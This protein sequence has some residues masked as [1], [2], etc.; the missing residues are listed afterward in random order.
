MLKKETGK[1]K[2]RISRFLYAAGGITAVALGVLGIFIPILPTTPFLL[3]AAYLFARSSQKLYRWLLTH[4]LLSI[5]IKNYIYYKAISPK[6]KI[7]SLSLLWASILYSCYITW[8][9]VWLP[10]LLIA[11]AI[12]VTIHILKLRNAP[13]NGNI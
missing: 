10:P 11:I 6:V 8:S 2:T 13:P 5:Y 4:R 9:K 1:P 12:G 7:V 3:L